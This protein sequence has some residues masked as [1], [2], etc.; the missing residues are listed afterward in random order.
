MEMS[1]AIV[2]PPQLELV[3]ALDQWYEA[4]N[5]GRF[6]TQAFGR[7]KSILLP[8]LE[9]K[10]GNLPVTIADLA[11]QRHKDL[12]AIPRIGSGMLAII[13]AFVRETIIGKPMQLADDWPLVPEQPTL[14]LL[15]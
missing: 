4:L 8:H 3:T 14:P 11:N 12:E 7:M 9:E 1:G 15:S 13:E 5:K 6:G 10:T 2:V